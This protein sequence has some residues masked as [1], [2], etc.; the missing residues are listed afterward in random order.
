MQHSSLTS[1]SAQGIQTFER[2][3]KRQKIKT[4]STS[5]RWVPNFKKQS[6]REGGCIGSHHD[7]P[8]HMNG[9][10]QTS[11][12]R[13]ERCKTNHESWKQWQNA[14]KNKT[15]HR[16]N[17]DASINKTN[18]PDNAP[19]GIMPSML[20]GP[21]KTIRN[22]A[23]GKSGEKKWWKDGMTL[24]AMGAKTTWPFAL[25]D[26]CCY[27]CCFCSFL[28]IVV[29]LVPAICCCC[30]SG[31]CLDL[32]PLCHHQMMLPLLPLLL[33][34][35][36]CFLKP[37][38]SYIQCH[39]WQN[40]CQHGC[41]C[42]CQCCLLLLS[43]TFTSYC[44]CFCHHCL[45]LLFCCWPPVDCCLCC[46]RGWLLPLLLQLVVAFVATMVACCLC[47]CLGWLLPLSPPLAVVILLLATSW[48]LPC[49]CHGQLLPLLPPSWLLPLFSL[50]VCDALMHCPLLF[51]IAVAV[52]DNV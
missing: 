20:L 24:H 31:H 41:H 32:L 44:C 51:V 39:H 23:W 33:S 7:L 18:H 13:R 26:W 29:I 4:Q 30:C 16:G 40:Y 52:V 50:A 43:C 6:R 1:G 2:G 12:A 8:H 17:A 9:W 5:E 22:L 49:C 15:N 21:E 37:F 3:K 34:L 28:L 47:C 48:L 42:F 46:H 10:H 25:P 38:G 45:L 11:L 36:D 14:S 35:V 19:H 27:F